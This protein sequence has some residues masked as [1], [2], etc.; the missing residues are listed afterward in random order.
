MERERDF[1]DKK[2]H[3]KFEPIKNLL[4]VCKLFY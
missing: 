1:C 4:F 3:K 2:S